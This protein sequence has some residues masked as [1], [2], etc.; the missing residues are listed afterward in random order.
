MKFHRGKNI[1]TNDERLVSRYKASSPM[2]LAQEESSPL[3]W[4]TG[5]ALASWSAT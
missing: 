5:M 4:V 3:K 2:F 1:Y